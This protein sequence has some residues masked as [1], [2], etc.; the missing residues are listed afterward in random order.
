MPFQSLCTHIISGVLSSSLP[1]RIGYAKPGGE[2]SEDDT[3]LEALIWRY[4][5]IRD[6]DG[7]WERPEGPLLV[8]AAWVYE[9]QGLIKDAEVPLGAFFG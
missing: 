8:P 1:R 5:D 3:S 6:A 2:P 7:E 9:A 4:G